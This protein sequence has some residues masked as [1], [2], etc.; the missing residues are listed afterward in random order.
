MIVIITILLRQD[1]TNTTM[2]VQPLEWSRRLIMTVLH[3]WLINIS[4]S[5]LEGK[6]ATAESAGQQMQ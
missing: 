6:L 4:K 1:V 5:A 3:I 2:A